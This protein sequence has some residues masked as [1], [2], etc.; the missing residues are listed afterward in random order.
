MFA[1]ISVAALL[2]LIYC[3]LI[4]RHLATVRADYAHAR[5]TA[6]AGHR[7]GPV[8]LETA[9]ARALLDGTMTRAE[10]RAMMEFVARR[11]GHLLRIPD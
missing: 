10:Y 1:T 9:A 3:V 7:A 8:D 2:V 11:S 5:R 6:E 4:A